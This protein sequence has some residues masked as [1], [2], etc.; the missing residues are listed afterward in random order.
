MDTKAIKKPINQF[1]RRIPKEIHV[2]NVVVFGSRN[3]NTAAPDSDIDVIVVSNDFA[4]WDEEK[5]LDVLYKAS[6]FIMPEIHP[7]AVTPKELKQASE[8]T[9]IGY[10]RTSGMYMM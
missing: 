6:R 9:T 1:L 5:R 7:W 2:E 10:A 4:A 8:L 3:T